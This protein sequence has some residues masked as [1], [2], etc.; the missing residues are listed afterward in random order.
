MVEQIRQGDIPGVQLRCRQVLAASPRQTWAW[1]TEVDRQARWLAESSELESDTAQAL[2][3]ETSD[4][5][6]APLSERLVVLTAN[7]PLEWVVDLQN[8]DGTWPVPTRVR[9]ELTAT[10]D[11]TE[12]SVLQTGFAHLPLSDC[13]TI[14]EAY[15]LRWRTALGTLAD[16]V[17]G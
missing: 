15:R 3:L 16:L 7:P 2:V 10:E 17:A 8:L 1:L 9:F 6:G 14:W 4:P 11:G 5:T 13:L 12:L